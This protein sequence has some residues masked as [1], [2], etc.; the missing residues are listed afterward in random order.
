MQFEVYGQTVYDDDLKRMQCQ[1]ETRTNVLMVL[2]SHWLTQDGKLAKIFL[3]D[4]SRLKNLRDLVLAGAWKSFAVSAEY[5]ASTFKAYDY[6]SIRVAK[7]FMCWVQS[8]N[9]TLLL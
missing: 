2:L 6:G 5:L 4:P 7:G 1:G 8:S 3:L 9:P